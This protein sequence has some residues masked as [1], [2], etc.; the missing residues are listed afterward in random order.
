[1]ISFDVPVHRDTLLPAHWTR[2]P[3]RLVLMNP[4]D[5]HLHIA[6]VL[7]FEI[8]EMTLYGWLVMNVSNV[9]L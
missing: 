2:L 1:M 9:L 4:S 8:T 5:V 7:C 6:V 3:E